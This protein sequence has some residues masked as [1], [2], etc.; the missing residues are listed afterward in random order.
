M[1]S[2]TTSFEP[3]RAAAA[4]SGRGFAGE[5]LGRESRSLKGSL[6]GP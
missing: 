4:V 3:N 6:G 2:M 1:D 5:I